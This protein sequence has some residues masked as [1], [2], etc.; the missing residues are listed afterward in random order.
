[1]LLCQRSKSIPDSGGEEVGGG[2]TRVEG[3]AT[4]GNA[5]S[6]GGGRDAPSAESTSPAPRHCRI[7]ATRV[8][9]VSAS[10]LASGALPIASR[11]RA[12]P[13]PRA[14][15]GEAWSSASPS[16]Q[17]PVD[18]NAGAATRPDRR[19]RSGMDPR[20]ARRAGQ[21]E[22]YTP[23]PT[24]LRPRSPGRL[25]FSAPAHPRLD[26]LCAIRQATW[27]TPP[28]GGS[29]RCGRRPRGWCRASWS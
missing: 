23:S 16:G 6:P 15:I 1:M 3:S 17:W 2:F 4:D 9:S 19:H 22:C 28:R 5:T 13:S 21:G 18:G 29:R 26:T 14:A 7:D 11:A 24:I 20:R 27:R 12:R 10:L 8:K 25:G